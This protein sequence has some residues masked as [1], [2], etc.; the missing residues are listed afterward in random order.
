METTKKS[1]IV[2]KKVRAEY[3]VF[4]KVEATSKEEAIR[5][6]IDITKLRR[7]KR[8]ESEVMYVR[9]VKK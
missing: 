6:D 3:I 7:P 2:K 5:H 4:Q 1:F 9:E 8:M